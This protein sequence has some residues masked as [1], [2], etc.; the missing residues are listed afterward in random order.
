MFATRPWPFMVQEQN[1]LI[2]M[3]SDAAELDMTDIHVVLP[4]QVAD[5]S[6]NLEIVLSPSKFI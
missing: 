4:V 3:E 2:K 6:P 1:Y 5:I